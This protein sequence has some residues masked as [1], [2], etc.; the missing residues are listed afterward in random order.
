ME[1]IEA[2]GNSGIKKIGL[3]L[4]D[5]Y[6][7]DWRTMNGRLPEGI[8]TA[9]PYMVA[10]VGFTEAYKILQEALYDEAVSYERRKTIEKECQESILQ[11]ER[12]HAEMK[13]IVSKYLSDR[14]EVIESGFKE[15]DRALLDGDTDGYLK[16]SSEIQKILGYDIQFTTQDEFDDLMDSDFA[17]KL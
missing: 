1:L 16:G 2:L 13:V 17:F 10:Y 8:A 6:D 3:D 7:I 14:Y 9:P 15:M 5:V 11:I 12:Y 4:L